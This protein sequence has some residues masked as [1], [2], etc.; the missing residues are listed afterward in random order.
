MKYYKN[1]LISSVIPEIGVKYQFLPKA[2][3][4]QSETLPEL[5]F[6]V[7]WG[8]IGV[9]YSGYHYNYFAPEGYR[10]DP[11][12]YRF[13]LDSNAEAYL[14]IGYN[15]NERYNIAL[16]AGISAIEDYHHTLPVSV[17]L[18]RF[19][20][21]DHMSDRWFSFI[22]L[23]SGLSIKEHPQAILTGK[24]GGGYRISL[25]K[26]TKL[27]FIMAYRCAYTHPDI[28]YYGDKIPYDRINRNNA[29]NSAI[30]FGMALT[31]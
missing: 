15:L 23:G 26:D 24:L 30:S 20:G 16:Y 17:R 13:I 18:T 27:D 11:R 25:S 9:F 12:R 31:L 21:K 4:A 29:Y 28:Y 3:K 1:G 19:H 10:A 5:T 7:E 22:D 14:H 6:G 8:Y 2:G